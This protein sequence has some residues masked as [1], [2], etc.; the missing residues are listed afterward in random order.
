M[1]FEEV[2]QRMPGLGLSTP[3]FIRSPQNRLLISLKVFTQFTVQVKQ[4]A[5][6]FRWIL[7]VIVF[8]PAAVLGQSLALR[9]KLQ[10]KTDRLPLSGAT[11]KITVQ[12]DSTSQRNTISG[13]DGSFEF[14]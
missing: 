6:M 5:H 7:F 14:R 2:A 11:V 10:D 3:P 12:N 13:R 4:Q 1:Y 9:G 8:F